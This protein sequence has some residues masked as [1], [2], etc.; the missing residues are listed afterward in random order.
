MCDEEC[1][2]CF[3]LHLEPLFSS[4]HALRARRSA[5][6]DRWLCAAVLLSA[7]GCGD[8][9]GPREPGTSITPSTT[10][11]S[12]TEPGF[13]D[14]DYTYTGDSGLGAGD[15]DD[16]LGGGLAGGGGVLPTDGGVPNLDGDAGG[17]LGGT[18]GT[19]SGT[20]GLLGGLGDAG[21]GGLFGGLGGSSD[22][23][24]TTAGDGGTPQECKNQICFD[25]FDCYILH[26]DKIDCGFTS[27]NFGTCM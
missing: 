17:L 1:M 11:D 14:G 2:R 26:P 5:R 9:A 18:G 19:L 21:L 10:G 7:I 15:G 24:A 13:G 3:G 6:L 16:N 20:G 4:N 8:G 23:G 12:G 25:V 27:C 22:A